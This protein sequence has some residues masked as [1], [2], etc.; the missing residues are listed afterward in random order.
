MD[1]KTLHT[2]FIASAITGAISSILFIMLLV[3]RT[4]KN[5]EWGSDDLGPS[6]I[7]A[8]SESLVSKP[9]VPLLFTDVGISVLFLAFGLIGK[10]LASVLEPSPRMIVSFCLAFACEAAASICVYV[11]RLRRDRKIIYVPKSIG[12]TGRVLKDIPAQLKGMGAIRI[13]MNGQ[14]VT[15]SA[16]SVDEVTLTKGTEVKVMY[17]DSDRVAVVERFVAKP[18]ID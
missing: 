11:Y 1:E 9:L 7:L 10:L 4:K 13:Y 2:L 14:V 6:D 8:P 17:A 3:A 18:D 12:L 5:E 16:L 15:V